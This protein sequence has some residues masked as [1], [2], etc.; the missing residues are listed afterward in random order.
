MG[1]ETFK[2]KTPEEILK[3]ISKL[4]QGRLKVYIGAVSGSGKTYHMLRE[5][6]LLKE[7]GIDVVICA[8]S[9]M[10]RPETVRQIGDLERVSSIHW[11]K[12]GIE[13]K[14]LNLE[15][16]IEH[17]PEVVLV[18]GLAHRNREGAL[19]PTRLEDIRYLLSKGISVITTVNVYE[20]EG[21]T[22]LAQ[23]LTGIE[24]RE[25]VSSD[26][27][28][29]ADEV[30]LIDAT[31]EM[32]LSRVEEGSVKA[33]KGA[34]I[35]KRGNLAVL[36]ELALRLVAV[37]VNDSLE[38]HREELGL[39]G[40]SGA[41][42]RILV[43]AQ[44]HW[45]GSIYVRRGQQIAK[46]LNGDLLVVAFVHPKKELSKEEA[47]FKRSM[48][49]LAEKVDGVFEQ[50]PFNSRRS[51]PDVLVN[52]ALAHRVTRIVLGHSKQTLWQELWQGSIV[53]DML[54]RTCNIDIFI[55]ADRAA[56][57]G[58]R[59]LP[60]KQTKRKKAS[61]LYRRLST[62][63][64]EREIEQL[65]K[66]RFKVYIGA[67]PG[68]GKTY[69]M[70]QEGN[71]LLKKGIGVQIG[72]LETHG[73]KETQAQIGELQMIPRQVID[74]RGTKLEEMDTDEIIRRKPE[75]VLVDELAHTNVPG[76]KNKKRYEDVL[77]LLSAGISVI[78]TV[79]VQHLESLNDAVEKLTGVR[80]RETVPDHILR[81]A[82][83]VQLIDVAPQTLRQRMREGRI[84]ALDKVDQALG[85]FFRTM[86]L[87]GL[88]ELALREIA[89]DV[90]ERLES[91]E[92]KSSLRGPWRR[93]ESIF[94]C[95]DVTPDAERLIRRGF[96]I[97]HRLKAVW[98]VAYV[99]LGSGAQ[100]SELDAR[101][102]QLRKLTERLGG[103]FQ[104]H[105]AENRLRLPEVLAAKAD[106]CQA[107]Q[108]II[109]QSSKSSLKEMIQGSVVKKLLRR[110]RHMD[111]LVVADA[112]TKPG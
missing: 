94:V 22:E 1:T 21:A 70:L 97:A 71:D 39:I 92:R 44:Y 77:E 83:E 57:E 13:K 87:I 102:E 84:Y 47:A 73:R 45:N 59:I 7:Q 56:H 75:V 46:R 112:E 81:L 76:S 66:G 24:V 54:K 99:Q 79:N 8:V 33:Q 103:V 27:L 63:E 11:Q 18:D 88:R 31:P 105:R 3:S 67:A 60:T 49:K 61:D 42:E 101:S 10:Q 68:V 109:G 48:V 107:T 64:V 9:T 19:F 96:R 100:S 41:A 37:G 52:Y 23:K 43:S 34:G 35:F 17:N 98:H 12:D 28:D 4:H 69:T 32:I 58:E 62:D 106:A 50:L 20:L 111:V 55:V 65:R 95:V 78:S 36:R 2:R 91:Y 16:L 108:L 5:G 29:L 93:Q 38:K 6:Q 30:V 86:N 89:D 14:D 25:T 74:Y 51:L 15:A 26:T 80:V 72:L 40:P 104:V 90:D 85:H 82:D 110:S 53:H